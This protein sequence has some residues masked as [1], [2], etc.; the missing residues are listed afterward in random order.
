MKLFA[1]ILLSTIACEP[2]YSHVTVRDNGTYTVDSCG[3]PW[4]TQD[5]G[6]DFSLK[7]IAK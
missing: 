4:D 1:L 2:V 7:G 5:D 3:S 6:V